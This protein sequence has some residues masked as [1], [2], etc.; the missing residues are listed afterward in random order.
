MSLLTSLPR[1][2]GQIM[3]MA[4]MF[5]PALLAF[6]GLAI[7]VGNFYHVK[8]RMQLAADAGAL[9]A[10]NEMWRR[11]GLGL[12]TKAA[13]DDTQR[14]G[15]TDKEDDVTVDVNVPPTSGSR[16]GDTAFVEVIIT[17]SLP[18]YFLRVV[19]RDAA[20]IRARAVAGLVQRTDGCIYALDPAK[21]DAMKVP[22]T[23]S[24]SAS[25]GILVNSNAPDAF[26]Q[27]G[28]ATVDAT[29]IGVVG[30]YDIMCCVNPTPE[31]GMLPFMDP[32]SDLDPP[33]VN[34]YPL[35]SSSLLQINDPSRTTKM[36]FQPGVYKGGMKFQGGSY[37]FLPGMYILDGG[38]MQ[39]VSDTTMTGYGV[40]FYNTNT[41]GVNNNWGDIHIG[42]QVI[43]DLH[44]PQ[45]GYYKGILLY[46]DRN[47]PVSY[48][49]GGEVVGTSTS[50]FEG[51][52]YFPT[53]HLKFHGTSD[54]NSWQLAIGNTV[55]VAGTSSVGVNFSTGYS[56]APNMRKA[57]LVE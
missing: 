6:T 48:T 47:Q 32:L 23:S 25:C 8:R 45:D 29:E 13:R 35:Q 50:T 20:T 26:S 21:N 43:A 38:G 12:F 53:R 40:T 15:F 3:L 51:V 1:R 18:T 36:T 7:D 49:Q 54:A 22:G 46:N 42:A 56:G 28:G 41:S 11:N 37:T 34:A 9:G 57:T 14:N 30:G 33:N 17:Q 52:L 5:L 10:A 19:N 2:R 55:S 31:V 24:L 4:A 27:E 16:A 39:V 44:A